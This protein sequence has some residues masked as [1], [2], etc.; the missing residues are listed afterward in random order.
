[1]FLLE[2]ALGHDD[3]L[4]LTLG[5]PSLP[6]KPPSYMPEIAQTRQQNKSTSQTE[7]LGTTINRAF[8]IDNPGARNQKKRKAN[9]MKCKHKLKEPLE[10]KQIDVR[11]KTEKREYIYGI[12]E[13]EKTK[14]PGHG[15][16]NPLPPRFQTTPI[17]H[18]KMSNEN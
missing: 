12:S 17:L 7:I 3:R 5:C 8:H 11:K 18:Q 16:K 9:E 10:K 1:M 6:Q 14:K 13:K 4:Q 2:R 15:K